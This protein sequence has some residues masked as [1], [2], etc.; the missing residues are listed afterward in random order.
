V[1]NQ[2]AVTDVARVLAELVDTALADQWNEDEQTM[3]LLWQASADPDDLRIAVKR[4]DGSVENELA[5]L[6]DLGSYLAVA[7]S[8]VTAQPPNELLPQSDGAPV[9]VTVA[10]DHKS[11]YGVLRHRNGTT[12]WF[13]AVDLPVTELLHSM[14]WFEPAR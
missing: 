5:P 6:S 3:A 1:S 11:E 8:A 2:E 14:L 12:Q 7:H 9:R 10:V 4:L 13:G